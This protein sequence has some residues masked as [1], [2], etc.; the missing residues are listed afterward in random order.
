MFHGLFGP[1]FVVLVS[2]VCNLFDWIVIT[3]YIASL[4]SFCIC[5]TK[6]TLQ[7][8]YG[9]LLTR[10]ASPNFYLTGHIFLCIESYHL[11][12]IILIQYSIRDCFRE[13][14]E[15]NYLWWFY[16]LSEYDDY[17]VFI[18]R[19]IIAQCIIIFFCKKSIY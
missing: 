14:S 16:L 18:C 1:D 6:R 7:K 9:K 15:C 19:N 12:L 2:V 3:S 17:W 5:S 13:C 4:T 11:V 8:N 10:F